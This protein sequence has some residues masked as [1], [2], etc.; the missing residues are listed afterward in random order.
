[1]KHAE[2]GRAYVAVSR[3]EDDNYNGNYFRDGYWNAQPHFAKGDSGSSQR[4][5]YYFNTYATYE[6]GYWQLDFRDQFS[7]IWPGN[8]DAYDGG[9]FQVTAHVDFENDLHSDD[10]SLT[11][12]TG[13]ADVRMNLFEPQPCT[14][15]W[16]CGS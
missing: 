4:H 16:G 2:D 8:A 14:S 3:H 12:E 7:E 11:L 1:M 15:W 9:Y 13:A 10:I 5:L 6:K